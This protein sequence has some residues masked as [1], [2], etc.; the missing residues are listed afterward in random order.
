MQ[1]SDINSN[2]SI[3]NEG[4][5]DTGNSCSFKFGSDCLTNEFPEIRSSEW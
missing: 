1:P 2:A 5:L 3:G 4:L